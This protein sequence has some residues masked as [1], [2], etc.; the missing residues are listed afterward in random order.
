MSRILL[1]IKP[2][3]V[4]QIL[5]GKKKWEYRRTIPKRNV[6]SIV[7]YASAPWKRVVCEVEVLGVK[8]AHHL[9]LWYD[10]K[11]YAGITFAEY[12]NYCNVVK[13]MHAFKLGK[14]HV[15]GPSRA[16]SDFGLVRAPQNFCYLPDKPQEAVT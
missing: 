16:L 12:L 13:D 14:I 8:S 4:R 15:F 11:P 6:T 2:K 5:Q 7:V 1:S 10:T 3:Y 9:F